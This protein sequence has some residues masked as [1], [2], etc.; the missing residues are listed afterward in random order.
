VVECGGYD[1]AIARDNKQQ[2]SIQEYECRPK[3][4]LPEFNRIA[5]AF[6]NRFG[7]PNGFGKAIPQGGRGA[8]SGW[9]ANCSIS[10]L[11]GWLVFR[12]EGA[13]FCI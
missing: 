8:N 12:E 4:V 10:R 9:H 7:G 5:T 2:I 1:P 13:V 3:A 11:G 6:Q